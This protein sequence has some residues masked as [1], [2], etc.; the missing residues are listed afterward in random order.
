[1]LQR[2]VFLTSAVLALG[3]ALPQLASAADGDAK[4]GLEKS[5]EVCALCHIVEEG[6]QGNAGLPTFIAIANDPAT[7]AARLRGWLAVPHPQMPQFDSLTARDVEDIIAYI[8]SL[9]TE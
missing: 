4:R 5:R 7:D 1:M 9:K 6:G 2:A 3:V 8:E